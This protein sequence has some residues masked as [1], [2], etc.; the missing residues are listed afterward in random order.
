MKHLYT[1]LH[2]GTGHDPVRLYHLSDTHL[3]LCDGRNDR[4]K[5]ELAAARRPMFPFA[6][7][8]LAEVMALKA[9]KDGLIVHTGD[10][11]DFTSEAN[12]D[13]TRAFARE[14]DCFFAAG[15]HEFSQYV[16]EAWE[17]AAYRAQSLARVQ[18]CF[19]TDIRFSSRV[20]GGVNLVAVDN[21]YYLFEA[22]QY[23]RLRAEVGKGLPIILLMHD[24]LYEPTVFDR[25]FAI[26]G[27]GYV[28]DAPVGRMTAYNEHRYRQQLA[29]SV[30]RETVAYIKSQPLIRAILC[31]HV[32]F[33]HEGYVT[34]TL[35]Q[36][37]ICG[38][39]VREILID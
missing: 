38:G 1:E 22:W 5:Q 19:A 39:E 31:G 15:N 35:P 4:R 34:P 17:D 2:I 12:F 37:V 29:D 9:E 33:S 7:S 30:T 27:A 16:G 18:S 14:S 32:H 8:D 36:Y 10:L 21:S 24:P 28:V 13:R 11:I 6:E 25:E 26:G 20:I 23:E 3:C